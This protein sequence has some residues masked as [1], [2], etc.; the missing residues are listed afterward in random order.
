MNV[1]NRDELLQIENVAVYGLQESLNASGYPMSIDT[2]QK[3]NPN[4]VMKRGSKL[5]QATPG[6][7]HDCYL[8][9]ITVQFDIT[10]PEY[11][12]RQLDRYHFIDYISSQSKMHRILKLDL[13]KQCNPFV[14][15]ESISNL[16]CLIDAYNNWDTHGHNDECEAFTLRDARKIPATKE[17]LFQ[18]IV[19]NIPAGLRLTARMTTNYLQL[20]TI[21]AQRKNHKLAEW[22]IFNDIIRELPLFEELTQRPVKPKPYAVCNQCGSGMIWQNDFSFED[23]GLDG[24]GLVAIAICSNDKCGTRAEFYTETIIPLDEIKAKQGK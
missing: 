6:S 3:Q 19:A 7:G 1:V 4:V 17:N 5:G 9:G 24:D 16:Q 23:Y 21:V 18:A 22:H 11:F 15:S 2:N 10:A 12:W 20:K 13:D 14:L 8:K